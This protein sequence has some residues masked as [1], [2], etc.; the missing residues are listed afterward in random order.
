MVHLQGEVAADLPIEP[1]DEGGMLRDGMEPFGEHSG[2]DPGAE[3]LFG[4]AAKVRL[5][6]SSFCGCD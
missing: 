2:V 5:N 4:G 6:W 3:D 1:C